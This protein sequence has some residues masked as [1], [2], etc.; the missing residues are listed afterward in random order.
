MKKKILIII[1]VFLISQT[2]YLYPQNKDRDGLIKDSD[3][4]KYENALTFLRLEQTDKALREFNEYLEIFSA[5][6]HRIE[7]YKSIAKIY[8]ER[9]DYI[10]ALKYYEALYEEFSGT[11]DGIEA[12]YN[13]AMCSIK[14]GNYTKASDVFKSIIYEYP[15]SNFAHLSKVNL[16]LL[17]II[18]NK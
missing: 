12:Y 2:Q 16:D 8:F 6:D 17:E 1:A 18:Q 7:S 3:N 11:S 13:A 4:R 5:G 15:D 14:M 10:K 9:F